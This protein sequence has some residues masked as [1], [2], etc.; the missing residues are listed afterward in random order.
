MAVFDKKFYFATFDPSSAQAVCDDTNS[1]G[2]L[3]GHDY[4]TP[5]NTADRA[6][7]GVRRLPDPQNSTLFPEKLGIDRFSSS[8]TK[9]KIIPGVALTLSPTCASFSSAPDSYGRTIGTETYRA[10]NP[11]VL[12]AQ[13]A[14]ATVN[15]KTTQTV[16]VKLTSPSRR[17]RVDSWAAIVE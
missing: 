9:G 3:W 16:E 6:S 1:L 7:A 15:D 17:A 8:T 4:V 5:F 12:K 14:G 13:V 11:Y 2:Y 10:A